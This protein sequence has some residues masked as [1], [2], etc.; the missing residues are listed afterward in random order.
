MTAKH[1]NQNSNP[2]PPVEPY[3]LSTGGLVGALIFWGLFLA[4][5]D[6]SMTDVDTAVAASARFDGETV[7]A[8]V[9][10][11]ARHDHAVVNQPSTAHA[12]DPPAASD[13]PMPIDLYRFALNA[14]LVPLMDDAV[15]PRWTEAAIDFNCGPGTSVTVDAAPLVAGQLIPAKTFTLRWDMDHCTPMGPESVALSGRVELVVSHVNGGLSAMVMPDRL[16]VDSHLGSAWLQGP[17]AAETSL[18]RALHRQ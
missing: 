4:A 18:V 10:H 13:A 15:P 6:S 8:T 3:A 2:C 11:F 9:T 1:S 5:C 17:F 12:P 7:A 16:R 14:L